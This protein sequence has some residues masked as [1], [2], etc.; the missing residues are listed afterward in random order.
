MIRQ[1]TLDD[2]PQIEELFDE[3]FRYQK[4]H[5]S[6]TIIRRGIFPSIPVI[7]QAIN[8]GALYVYEV[9]GDILGH[10]IFDKRQPPEFLDFNWHFDAPSEATAVIH[11]I[12]VRPRAFR[13]GIARRLLTFAQEQARAAGC[14]VLRTECGSQNLPAVLLLKH[15]GFTRAGIGSI[16]VSGIVQAD[17]HIFFEKQL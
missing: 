2:L 3:H 10:I 6:Y 16:K 14:S 13:H 15:F 5:E 12:N 7:T 4:R 9:D 1:G 17:G 8:D 11:M